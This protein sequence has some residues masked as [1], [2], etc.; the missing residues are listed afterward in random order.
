METMKSI[1]K[2]LGLA[3]LSLILTLAFGLRFWPVLLALVG[4]GVIY[5]IIPRSTWFDKLLTGIAAVIVAWLIWVAAGA[6]AVYWLS[7]QFP[8][9]DRVRPWTQFALDTR[10]GF[11][12]KPDMPEAKALILQARQKAETAAAAR[13]KAAVEQG[14]FDAALRIVEEERQRQRKVEETLYPAVV[15]PALDSA[16]DTV[17]DFFTP[18][19]T[20]AGT[21]RKP[22]V[23]SGWQRLEVNGVAGQTLEIERL[24]SGQAFRVVS[25]NRTFD[26]QIAPASCWRAAQGPVIG[27]TRTADY[28]GPLMAR[29]S[30]ST[31]A[32]VEIRN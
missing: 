12:L 21:A 20:A 19:P 10:V 25:T 26:F 14:D 4:L 28:A 22:P 18:P 15:G 3:F 29:F 7:A 9:I 1:G 16:A 8:T 13:V 30:G 31:R 27:Q 32:V 2:W 23:A 17:V 6:G 11:W 5:K 24:R